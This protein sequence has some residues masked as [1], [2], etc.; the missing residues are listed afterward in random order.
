M[1]QIIAISNP[2]SAKL[3]RRTLLRGAATGVAGATLNSIAAPNVS[4]AA[5][6]PVISHGLQSGDVCSDGAVIWA[7]TDRP[8]RMLVEASTTESFHTIRATAIADAFPESD[9]TAK[10]TLEGLS[11]GQEIFYR[12]RF[13]DHSSPTITSEMQSGRFR[14]APLERRSLSFVWSGDTAGQGFGIDE[15][16]GGMRTFATM[17]THQPDF[18]IHSGDGIYAD[19]AIPAT[20]PLPNGE[21][22][23]NLVTE[24]KSKVAETLAEFRGNYKYNLLDRNVRA[25]NLQVPI[26]A[27]WDD[28][29]V[30]NDWVPGESVTWDRYTEKSI[31]AL[32][33]RGGRAFH[34]FMPTRQ[35]LV[36][37][38]RVYR[39]IAYGPLLDI[40]MVD[41][42]SYRTSN[43]VG[44]DSEVFGVMQLAW[45][46]RELMNSRATWKI[47]AADLPIGLI[48][49]DAIALGDGPPRGRECEIADLLAFIKHGGITNIAWLTA[50]MHY[51]AAHFYDPNRAVFQDF[52]PFW[53]FVSGPLHAGTW[54]PS[55]LDN[56]FG[57]R[58]V[59]QKGCA[60]GQPDGLAPCFGLQFFGHVAI[61]GETEVMTVSLR[62]VDDE[63]LWS[64]AIEPKQSKN[65]VQNLAHG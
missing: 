43:S 28:H 50:D 1:S 38:G 13:Q 52:E 63:L 16:R 51:T 41:M 55:P 12:V 31:L 37:A 46:K 56:T 25:F 26:F 40:F 15:T 64:T 10:M 5:S 3:S 59:F 30:T 39:K 24:E 60:Q 23:I 17:L 45:L 14:T 2:T 33:A 21:T 9:F 65:R 44:N 7:R 34:E 4:F 11:A 22:W 32:A 61:D 8:A 53:E 35:A 6:R 49:D 54:S 36:E 19:C 48:S 58:A 62:D 47:I 18:F 27:Q 57:P 20:V 42:R 29:E